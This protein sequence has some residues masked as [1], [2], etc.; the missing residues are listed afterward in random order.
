MFE[1]M[2]ADKVHLWIRDFQAGDPHRLPDER[3]LRNEEDQR[4]DRSLSDLATIPN[5]KVRFAPIVLK[6]PKSRHSENLA[7]VVHRRFHPLQ[8]SVESI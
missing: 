5:A 7:N 4:N 1:Q 8:G 3:N 6:T 2:K